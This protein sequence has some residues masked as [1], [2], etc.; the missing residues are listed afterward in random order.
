MEKADVKG[1]EEELTSRKQTVGLSIAV[2]SL[3]GEGKLTTA[4]LGQERWSDLLS[5]TYSVR[6]IKIIEKV[7]QALLI[8]ARAVPAFQKWWQLLLVIFPRQELGHL[9]EECCQRLEKLA[10]TFNKLYKLA[11]ITIGTSVFFGIGGCNPPVDH[12]RKEKPQIVIVEEM[13]ARAGQKLAGAAKNIGHYLKAWKFSP[14]DR[15]GLLLKMRDQLGGGRNFKNRYRAWHCGYRL[16]NEKPEVKQ[17]VSELW[18]DLLAVGT[19]NDWWPC[20]DCPGRNWNWFEGLDEKRGAVLNKL[21]DLAKKEPGI[22]R[23]AE[24]YNFG[25]FTQEDEVCKWR[26]SVLEEMVARAPRKLK[27]LQW[28][29][30]EA[31]SDYHERRDEKTLECL[32]A[33]LETKIKAID[34]G[35]LD[36]NASWDHYQ[37]RDCHPW[38]YFLERL[39]ALAEGGAE[40]EKVWRCVEGENTLAAVNAVL[41]RRYGYEINN[42][43]V[44]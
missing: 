39:A 11:D 8:K 34:I 7:V 30:H 42:G 16:Q 17:I 13:R 2:V 10:V 14:E 37:K 1:I 41:R 18:R 3:Q 21:L 31:R 32:Q 25:M 20:L 26:L 29:Y 5:V 27:T 33:T 44:A 35:N 19:I 9:V 24:I 23:L 22:K 15:V 36:F 40:W 28:L 12:D 6:D 43:N 4:A 38:R